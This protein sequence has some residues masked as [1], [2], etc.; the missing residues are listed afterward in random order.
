MPAQHQ[1]SRMPVPA[2]K[3]IQP[4]LFANLRT[5]TVPLLTAMPSRIDPIP[6]LNNKLRIQIIITRLILNV[7]ELFCCVQG[8][9]R[10]VP[11][12]INC[13]RKTNRAGTGVIIGE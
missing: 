4:F 9:E 6:S 12:C 3:A 5:A 2:P 10:Q 1:Q 8:L 7:L 13:D 11:A